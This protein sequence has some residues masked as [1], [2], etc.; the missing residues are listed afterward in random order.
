M[1]YR[2]FRNSVYLRNFIFGVEDSLVSTVGLLSGL[3]SQGVSHATILLT[4]AIYICVEGFSMAVGSYLSEDSAR[5]YASR[6]EVKDSLSFFGSIVM[7]VSFVG[8]GFIPIAPYM[9]FE[10]A[11]AVSYSIF[12]SILALFFLGF[13]NGRLS[14][15]RPWKR[16][17]RMA[18]LGGVAILIGVTVG[19]FFQ[20][21]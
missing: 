15:L 1:Y 19:V 6:A 10:G 12:F 20:V 9:A 18:V 5:E 3:A 4:G 7:F 14:G 11:E 13:L 2:R 16:A 21:G 8:A 17:A